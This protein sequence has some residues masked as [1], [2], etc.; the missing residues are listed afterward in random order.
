MDTANK[1]WFCMKCSS[2]FDSNSIFS[3]HLKLLHKNDF[4]AKGIKS[5][6]KINEL[7]QDEAKYAEESEINERNQPI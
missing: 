4:E 7:F 2:Q 3:L 6:T 5:E 1:N